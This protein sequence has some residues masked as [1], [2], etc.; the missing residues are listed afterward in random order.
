MKLVKLSAV[1]CGPCK[2]IAPIVEAVT[3]KYG[4]ELV[5]VDVDEQQEVTAQYRVRGVPTLVLVDDQGN[6]VSRKVGGV[7]QLQL[8]KWI[9]QYNDN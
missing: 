7:S 5:E 9:E 6:E 3:E 8:E 2:Q 4:I 1:W